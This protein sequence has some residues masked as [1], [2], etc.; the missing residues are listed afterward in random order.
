MA[1]EPILH[2]AYVALDDL[3]RLRYRRLPAPSH[4]ARVMGSQAGSRLSKLRGRGID[5]SEVRAY[6]PG[7]DVRTI[8]WRVTARKN[9]P[10]TKVFREERERLTLIVVDQTQSMFFGSEVR[11]KSVAAA[12]LAALGAWQALQHNDRVGGI[13]IGNDAYAAHKP[14]RNVKSV[15]RFLGDLVKMNTA[16]ARGGTHPSKDHFARALGQIRRLARNNY[17]I[18]F[19]SD[20]QP[21]GDHWREAFR[22]LSRHN[23][24]IAIRVFDPLE[25]ELPP[26]DSYT[27]TDGAHR[28]Q[29]H[30]GNPRLRE[31]YHSRFV[32]QEEHLKTIC[33]QTLV[34]YVSVPTSEPIV[35]LPGWN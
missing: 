16:L 18:Y 32:T 30:A 28:L 33:Q 21:L 31:R 26:A 35:R 23:E 8:D 12:E 20:F 5:F 2:G 11:L 15:A 19:I 34:D 13:V 24:V 25:S 7:D 6:Q 17:R 10:H 1:D 3:F 27:V 14:Y 4:T 29:F 22:S 9:K